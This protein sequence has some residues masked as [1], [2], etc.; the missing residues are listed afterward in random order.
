[1]QP[2]QPSPQLLPWALAALGLSATTNATLV[3]VAGDASNRRYFRLQGPASVVI[4][5]EAPPTTEKNHEFLKVRELLAGARVRV[6]ALLA[7]DLDRGYM[8]LEDL[9]D[10]LLLPLL[11]PALA[12]DY[13]GQ[14]LAVLRQLAL[15]DITHTNL[16]V[17]DNALLAEE[18]SRFPEWFLE[19]LLGLVISNEERKL[20]DEVAGLLIGSAL[21]QPQVLVHRDFH[22]RNLM[23]VD[24]QTL[25]VIDF[26]DAVLGPVTYDAVSLLR[27]C[28]IG[29]PRARVEAWA[30]AHRDA[31]QVSGVIPAVDDVTFLCWF[32][33]MGLQ[34]HLKVLGTFARLYLRD[35]KAGYL[36]DL[37][38]TIS[39][40]TG[41]LEA[42][43]QDGVALDGFRRWFDRRVLPVVAQQAW[44]KA[45]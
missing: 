32:D 24:E 20:L 43:A 26:Q 45:P 40:I 23:C 22:S 39:H 7:A 5:V 44:S 8:L 12:D 16:P 4:V 31:L 17:Y 18:F 36:A 9:G 14:A 42:R 38:L 33:L 28:Y 6:P 30:L 34:R 3:P 19:R 1:M 15:V 37:P 11:T 35:G 13:Y 10:S 25:A 41:V 21:A 27:D 2:R 29:W